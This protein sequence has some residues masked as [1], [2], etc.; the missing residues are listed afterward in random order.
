MRH[1]IS[2]VCDPL[3]PCTRR[4]SVYLS[5]HVIIL[6]FTPERL[7]QGCKGIT[8][9]WL[10]HLERRKYPRLGSVEQIFLEVSHSALCWSVRGVLPLRRLRRKTCSTRPDLVLSCCRT[11]VAYKQVAVLLRLD[12]LFAVNVQ[13]KQSLLSRVVAAV[14]SR[15][16]SSATT[17][18]IHPD[19]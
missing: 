14:S 16:A 7:D 2:R 1:V 17:I 13:L 19:Y 3:A 4:H 10:L 12:S 6:N 9:C 15:T 18:S 8:S 11:T 5:A